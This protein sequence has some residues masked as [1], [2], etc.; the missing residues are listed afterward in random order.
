MRQKVTSFAQG[1]QLIRNEHVYAQAALLMLSRCLSFRMNYI[2]RTLPPS[3][4]LEAA[5]AF[6][7]LLLSVFVSKLDLETQINGPATRQCF[8]PLRRGGLGLRL[9]FVVLLLL[10][11]ALSLWLCLTSL[12]SLVL[13]L[14]SRLTSISSPF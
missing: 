6:D 8:V 12:V 5:R 11:L 2:L 4:T 10:M 7:K 1:F 13:T 9:L 3:V 14:K